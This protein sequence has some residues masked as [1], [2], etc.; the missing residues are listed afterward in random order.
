V[1]TTTSVAGEGAPGKPGGFPGIE[2]LRRPG[3]TT[4][5]RRRYLKKGSLR[6]NLVSPEG[7]SEASDATEVA[8][9]PQLAQ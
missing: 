4:Q 2:F 5:L 8:V 6:G 1:I 9:E 3:G 7:A